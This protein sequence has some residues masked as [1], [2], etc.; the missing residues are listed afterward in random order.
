M[1]EHQWQPP[2][3]ARARADALLAGDP[4][5]NSPAVA[6]WF[7]ERY[8]YVR[9]FAALLAI[10]GE[11]R[12]LLGPREYERLWERHL[13]NSAALVPFLA[14]G[15]TADVGSGAGLPGLVIA[16]MQPERQ[17]TLIEPMERRAAWLRDV[18]GAL[19]LENVDVVRARAEEVDARFE[20]VTARAVAAIDK[21]V[22][23]CAPL[24]GVSG[25]MVFL[26]GRSANDELERAKF[27]LRK[28]GLIGEVMSA[29]T[30]PGLEPT[31]V[32]RLRKA[33]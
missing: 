19:G 8:E 6:E 15:P 21:L 2:V 18:S 30:L 28:A 23:W 32:V 33:S 3:D 5:H 20:V 13:L 14:P 25:E 4:L 9:E 11:T 29:P 12:G 27:S 10:E 16:A 24:L 26:K 1:T 31:T 17:L 7:G 22:K